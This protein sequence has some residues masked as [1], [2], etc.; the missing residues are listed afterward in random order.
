MNVTVY[1]KV[2][3]V[4]S[5]NEYSIQVDAKASHKAKAKAMYKGIRIVGR[6]S[7]DRSVTQI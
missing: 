1:I 2:Y 7:Q 3:T 6:Q 5:M 4:C